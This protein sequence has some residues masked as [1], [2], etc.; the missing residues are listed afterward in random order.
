MAIY[1]QMDG[2]EGDAT[3]EQHK[4]WLTIESMH[5]GVGRHVKAG[6]GRAGNREASEPSVSEV[7]ITKHAD[8]SSPKIFGEACTGKKGKTVKIDFVTTGNPGDTYMQYILSDTLVSSYSI[9]SGGDRP[10]ESIGLSFSKI[11][12]KFIPYD[13]QHKAASPIIANYDLAT[14]KSG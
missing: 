8:G 13:E 1:V 6:A 14:T 7:T 4:K 5:W 2:I 3:Q 11:E 12:M 10:S 9:S